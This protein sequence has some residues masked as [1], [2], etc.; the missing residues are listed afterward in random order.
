MAGESQRKEKQREEKD[1]KL[2][3]RRREPRHCYTDSSY[4][5]QIHSTEENIDVA[6]QQGIQAASSSTTTGTK[7]RSDTYGDIASKKSKIWYVFCNCM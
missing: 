1:R 5:E 2:E 3:Q 4:T 6:L 7:R